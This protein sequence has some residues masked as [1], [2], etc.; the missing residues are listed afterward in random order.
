M[1]KQQITSQLALF[2]LDEIEIQIYLNLLEGRAKTPLEISRE[3]SVNRTKIYRYLERLKGKKLIEESNIDRGLRLKA[4]SPDNLQLLISEKEQQLK[5]QKDLLPDLV[6]ELNVIPGNLKNNFEIKYYH[7]D[8]GL[9]QM[10][11]NQLSAEKRI[12]NFCYQTRN[13]IV[14]ENF[15]EKIREEQVRK[16]ITLY[17]IEN[18]IDPPGLLFTHVPGF[19]KYYSHRYVS[20]KTIQIN[21][22]TAVF[23]NTVSIMSWTDEQKVGVELVNATYALMQRQLFWYCWNKVAVFK[24]KPVKSEK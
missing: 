16:R 17:E 3:T 5:A 21:Q 22:N 9:K 7:G 15:A 1:N 19:N 13:E 23:N 8:E 11:W 14:G 2:G 18:V 10:L 24:E 4:A 6:K 20:P 12:I